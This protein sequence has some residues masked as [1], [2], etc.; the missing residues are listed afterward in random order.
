MKRLSSTPT[1]CLILLIIFLATVAMAADR[2]TLI[3]AGG[4][5]ENPP[6]EFLEN[7]PLRFRLEESLNI[8]KL[9]GT[10]QEIYNLLGN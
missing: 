10:Y 3:I 6:Y 2:P 8:L 9:N 7:D 4:D 5:H 1:A